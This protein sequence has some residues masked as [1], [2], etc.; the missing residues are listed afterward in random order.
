MRIGAVNLDKKTLIVAEIGNNHEGNF[1]VAQELVCRAA[2]A[3]VDAV[4]FQTF[5]TE[6]FVSRRDETHFRRLKSFE[7]MFGQFEKLSLLARSLGMIFLSTPLDLGSA[8]FLEGIVD[9]Y[10]IA[11]GDNNFYPLIR[12]AVQSGKPLIISTGLS[13]LAQVTNTVGFVKNSWGECGIKGELAI[14]HC[15]SNYPVSPDQANLRSIPFLSEKFPEVT[16][17][18]SDHTVGIEASLLAVALGARIIEKHFTLDKNYSDFR[19]HQL[20]SDPGEM[21]DLV[22]KIRLTEQMLGT[23]DK[24]LQ[25]CE[26]DV[27][28]NIRRSVA[29]L[30]DLPAGHLMTGRDLIWIRPGGGLKPG[31]ESAVIGKKLRRKVRSGD[32]LTQEDLE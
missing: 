13:D 5:R 21:R 3:G 16:I 23:R 2:E 11:S 27:A 19:D 15:V 17:G 29:T 18:Y 26:R 6:Q 8:D 20:S 9:A 10:K 12:R 22:K 4:K 24:R 28:Q 31:E 32:F 30:S 25:P 7:L 1:E 14:L